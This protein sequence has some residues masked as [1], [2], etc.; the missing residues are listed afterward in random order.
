MPDGSEGPEALPEL[1]QTTVGLTALSHGGYLVGKL[2][3]RNGASGAP[4]GGGPGLAGRG[5]APAPGEITSRDKIWP[6]S[7]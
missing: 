1:S 3:P 2:P 7:T 6:P 5:A 4:A